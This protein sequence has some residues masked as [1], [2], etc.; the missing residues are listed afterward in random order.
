MIGTLYLAALRA[1]V[2]IATALD[3]PDVATECERLF[4][5]VSLQHDPSPWNVRVG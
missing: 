1:A 5:S 2:E 4:A 3:D